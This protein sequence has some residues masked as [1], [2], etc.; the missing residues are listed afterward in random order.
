[1]ITNNRSCFLLLPPAGYTNHAET[2]GV[3][4][5]LE[6]GPFAAAKASWTCWLPPS[7]LGPWVLQTRPETPMPRCCCAA[8]ALMASSFNQTSRPPASMQ[9]SLWRW[10]HQVASYRDTFGAPM[11]KWMWYL[12]SC[13]GTTSCPLMWRCPGNCRWM[14]FIHP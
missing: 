8:S 9:A 11:L 6:L 3:W 10:S 5:M 4:N 13:H 1:M 7:Q 2:E 14:I 12:R